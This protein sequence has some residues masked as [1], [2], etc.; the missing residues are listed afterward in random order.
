MTRRRLSRSTVLQSLFEIDSRDIWA[1]EEAQDIYYRIA[2]EFN[3]KEKDHTYALF[4][5]NGILEKKDSIDEIIKKSVTNWD[6][7]KITIID[8]NVIRIGIFEL[9]FGKEID[10]P[11]RVALNEAIDL[12]R[13]FGNESS[14]KFINGVLG[15]IYRE[16]GEPGK[17]SKTKSDEN[18]DKVKKVVG[19]IVYA[20]KEDRVMFAFVHDIFNHWAISKGS[21]KT[22]QNEI[23]ELTGIIKD[24]IGLDVNIEYKIGSNTYISNSPKEGK[25]KKEASYYLAVAEYQ[26]LRLKET[27]GLTEARWFTYEEIQT[28][29]FYSDMR[30]M[31]LTTAEGVVA[32]YK[33]KTQAQTT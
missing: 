15:F 28:L 32:R 12:A 3:P 4:I 18:I 10:V 27:G 8:R 7:E 14:G 21:I 19:A 31:I 1:K 13:M 16:M 11:E 30:K 5:L 2:E 6:I 22:E 25:V 9:L 29:S 24:E 20:V 26:P 23:E 17:D 33:S